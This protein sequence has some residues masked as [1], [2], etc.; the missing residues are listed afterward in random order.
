MATTPEFSRVALVTGASQGI[1]RSIALRLADDGLDLAVNDVESKASQLDQVV[2]EI[3][4]KGRRAVP[5]IADVSSE[6][7]VQSMVSNAVAGL[8]GLDVV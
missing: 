4:S 7:A 5:V 3:K 1:G 8:G 6:K 2:Q